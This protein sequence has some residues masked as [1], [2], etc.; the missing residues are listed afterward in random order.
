MLGKDLNASPVHFSAHWEA[1][2]VWRTWIVEGEP[3]YTGA[4]YTG[5]KAGDLDL[6]DI[7]A[8]QIPDDAVLDFNLPD[9]EVWET[10]RRVLPE[11]LYDSSLAVVDGYAYMFGG[12]ITDKIIRADIADPIAWSTM[13]AVLPAPL[14]GS[15]L[16]VVDGY[17]YLFG[18]GGIDGYSTSVIYR[19]PT[20]DPL[21]WEDT[22]YFLPDALSYS[23]LGIIDGYL[24]LYGGA[25]EIYACTEIYKASVET[26]WLWENTG[27][28]IPEP[29]FGHQLAIYDGYVYLIGG[30]DINRLPRDCVYQA[31]LTS[32][33]EFISHATLPSA[34]AFGQIAF[35]GDRVFYIGGY[36]TGGSVFRAKLVDTND[37]PMTFRDRGVL[38]P[39]TITHSQV[40]II[41][42]RILLLGGNGS[43]IIWA[44]GN[45]L[46]YDLLNPQVIYYSNT[47]RTNYDA[48]PNTLDLFS[49]IGFPPWKTDYSSY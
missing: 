13:D 10:T 36:G 7:I 38:I 25:H 41:Y 35:V 31:P 26:P 24:Y 5:L 17:I 12:S 27:A 37:P 9:G 43:T 21:S 18:G 32:P 1:G 48:I 16:A 45:R 14:Y 2:S 28:V 11:N 8:Y 33:T 40:A 30:L 6:I 23:Q 20:S 47:T 22:G 44:S 19:A 46:Q 49:L 29:L 3:D 4:Q 34:T 39:G 42:D 15:Q